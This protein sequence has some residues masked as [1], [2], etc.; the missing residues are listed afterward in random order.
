MYALYSPI[1]LAAKL[2]VLLQIKR[3]FTTKERTLFWWVIWGS[4]IGNVLFYA[5]LFFSYVFQCHPREKIWNS[6]IE[7]HCVDAIGLNLASGILNVISDIETLLLPIWGIW[8]LQMP[9]K[10]KIGVIAV[11]GVGSIACVIGVVGIY[12]RVELFRE[13][14]FTWICTQAALLV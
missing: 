8:N 6:S 9:M 2:S 12:Y 3:I 1:T 14:D 5:G 13:P 4:I 11:F 10:K 7:G